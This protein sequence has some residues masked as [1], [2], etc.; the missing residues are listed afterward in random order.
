MEI[1]IVTN[2]INGKIYVGQSTK[3]DPTYFGSGVSINR[4]IAKYGKE[5]F[6]KEVIETCR[7]D[8]LNEREI[9]WISYYRS[10]EPH[11]GYNLTHGGD[12]GDTISLNPNREDIIKRISESNT[13]KKFTRIHKDNISTAKKGKSNGCEGRKY[14]KETIQKMS[15]AKKNMPLSESHKESLR[16]ARRKRTSSG[17]AGTKRTPEQLQARREK[18]EKE[19]SPKGF[20]IIIT[21]EDNN[22]KEFKSAR[23]AARTY[24]CTPYKIL[25]N[26]IK[27]L[28]II[29]IS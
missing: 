5:N 16:I 17:A 10:A 26:K 11:I 27:K 6:E 19:G 2:K 18:Y 8:D 21:D 12:G 9:Y 24:N 14:S 1:Y 20:A 28:N 29:I 7:L 25:N 22:V 4:A 13:G 3:S 15:E 23:E